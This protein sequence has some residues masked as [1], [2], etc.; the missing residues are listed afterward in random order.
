MPA[1]PKSRVR[2]RVADSCTGDKCTRIIKQGEE[3]RRLER[4]M[5]NA[6]IRLKELDPST[7]RSAKMSWIEARK[8]NY[9]DHDVNSGALVEI[10]RKCNV[11]GA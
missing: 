9:P 2:N 1:K 8:S 3:V 4:D 5:S 6:G 7:A 10:K 11:C